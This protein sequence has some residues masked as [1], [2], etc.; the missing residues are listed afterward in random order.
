MIAD[1]L[2]NKHACVKS[3]SE[4]LGYKEFMWENIP[5]QEGS[6]TRTAMKG[7]NIVRKVKQSYDSMTNNNSLY[8]IL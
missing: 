1:A 6:G 7:D 4:T 2:K 8:N 3:K 5:V